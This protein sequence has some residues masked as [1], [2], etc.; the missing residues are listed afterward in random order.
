MESAAQNAAVPLLSILLAA[1][2]VGGPLPPPLPL[3]PL[4]NW[5]NSDVSNAPVDPHSAAYISF[6]GPTRGMHPDFGG[7]SGDPSAPIY[8]MPYVGVDGA[9]PLVPVTFDYDDESDVAAPGRPSGYPIP[10]EAK[11]QQK[12]IEGGLAGNQGGGGDRHM[13]IVDRDPRIDYELYAVRR[14]GT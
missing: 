6:I 7:D 13:L 12:W 4:T 8:G 9:Q 3:F 14:A 1:A 10:E 11:T 2:V 5:W